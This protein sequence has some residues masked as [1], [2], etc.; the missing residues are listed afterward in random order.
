[1]WFDQLLS[2]LVFGTCVRCG[3]TS[4]SETCASCEERPPHRWQT[5]AGFQVVSL[6]LYRESVGQEVRLL[7]Y[8][9]ETLRAHR[10]GRAL[11]H[12]VPPA[13]RRLTCVP[14]PLHPERLAERGYNQAA[15]IARALGAKTGAAVDTN[16][17]ARK[18]ATSAQARLG[19]EERASNLKGA[20][21]SSVDLS[22]VD[23]VI[24]DD[25]VTTG[26]SADACCEA[27]SARGARVRGILCCALSR[28]EALEP[29]IKKWFSDPR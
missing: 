13:W 25:V 23:L 3:C 21:L 12:I 7:K 5:P 4:F 14:M 19:P 24:L 20:F 6:G 1:V 9:G 26:H 22:G 2:G 15:L 18:R 10:L 28:D 16:V 17:L 27:L 8:S 29:P 11:S